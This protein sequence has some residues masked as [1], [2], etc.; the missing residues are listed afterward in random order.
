MENS[1]F[2]GIQFFSETQIPA[3][4]FQSL[5]QGNLRNSIAKILL[6]L[7]LGNTNPQGWWYFLSKGGQRQ[8][9]LVWALCITI[10]QLLNEMKSATNVKK[11]KKYKN[12][13]KKQ[14][15]SKF[16]H[17]QLDRDSRA[18][19]PNCLRPNLPRTDQCNMDNLSNVTHTT[20]KQMQQSKKWKLLE[21]VTM[22]IGWQALCKC[23]LQSPKMPQRKMQRT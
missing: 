3:K 13:R 15:Q 10:H 16:G 21:H 14:A 23:I 19:R 5:I 9:F 7:I 17:G 6:A 20:N 1:V 4:C 22:C 8:I 18:P 12:A 11:Y 2:V